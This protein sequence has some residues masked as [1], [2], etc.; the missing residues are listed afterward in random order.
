MWIAGLAVSLAAG[1]PTV[2]VDAERRIGVSK[3]DAHMRLPGYDGRIGIEQRGRWSRRY[4]KKSFAL[5]TRDAAGDNLDA[6]LLGMPADDDWILY[7]AYNDRTLLRNALAYDTARWMGRYAAR[8]RFVHLR[9][10]GRYHGV[11]VLME[12]LK[13][14]R[15]RVAVGGGGHL[16]E[17]TSPRQARLKDPSFRL[18]ITRRPVVWKDP[19][20]PEL[21]RARAQAIRRRAVALERALY[22]G[23]RGAW[24]RHLHAPSAV[25]FVLVNELFKNEDAFRASTYLHAP[26]GRRLRLGPVWDFDFA[27][28]NSVVGLSRSAAGSFLHTRPLVQRLLA[29][30]GF[31]RALARRWRALRRAGLRARLVRDVRRQT[32]ALAPAARRDLRRWP[33]RAERPPGTTAAHGRRLERWLN[34]RVAWMDRAL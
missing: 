33:A 26:A 28:G 19:E 15:D 25:D 10:N 5:E 2:A 34:A 21:T 18:P 12:Q 1:L 17:L 24:R 13:V 14:H 16:L 22:R 20:R 32:S 29:E 9:L 31:R 30:P 3:V 11:Y 7:A 8:T 4:P 23:V 27:A 6:G